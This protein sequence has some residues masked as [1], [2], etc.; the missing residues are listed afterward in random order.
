MC[1]PPTDHYPTFVQGWQLVQRSIK[2]RGRNQTNENVKII[3]RQCVPSTR[4]PPSRGNESR[5]FRYL[6]RYHCTSAKG[7]PKLPPYLH[8]TYL[9]ISHVLRTSPLLKSQGAVPYSA[10]CLFYNF[11]PFVPSSFFNPIIFSFFL[12]PIRPLLGRPSSKFGVCETPKGAG[13]PCSGQRPTSTTSN[14]GQ[15][16]LC[17]KGLVYQT[18]GCSQLIP[19]SNYHYSHN[20][21]FQ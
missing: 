5:R 13:H 6:V 16:N 19:S 14:R 11:S 20:Q 15:K 9:K 4:E 18:I 17:L 21:C 3:H 10:L 1:C 7:L 2:V 12:V 8:T